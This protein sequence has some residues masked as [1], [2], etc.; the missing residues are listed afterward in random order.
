MWPQSQGLS[1]AVLFSAQTLTITGDKVSFLFAVFLLFTI[2][3]GVP[4]LETESEVSS[5]DNYLLIH[6]DLIFPDFFDRGIL[7]VEF[8]HS[9]L[10]MAFP[11]NC[12]LV[13]PCGSAQML[14]ASA[15]CSRQGDQAT[16]LTFP[17]WKITLSRFFPPLASV[18]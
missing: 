12:H 2:V 16:F 9:G 3:G 10:P 17:S 15:S 6:P 7:K 13:S 18:I 1:I 14:T 11:V 8:Q 4:N 5:L